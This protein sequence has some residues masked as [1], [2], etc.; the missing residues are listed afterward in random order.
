MIVEMKTLD[1]KLSVQVSA[2]ITT[3]NFK[4]REVK[5]MRFFKG[6]LAAY[7]TVVIYFFINNCLGSYNTQSLQHFYLGVKSFIS[8][9]TA[10]IFFGS[11]LI[12]PGC[13]LG[14]LLYNKYVKSK[15]IITG[16]I[17]FGFL[18]VTYGTIILIIDGGGFT[19][20]TS[21]LSLVYTITI[22][23]SILFYLFR[24]PWNKR[25]GQVSKGRGVIKTM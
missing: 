1:I 14:E 6:C 19:S 23:G 8:D 10:I 24:R 20:D 22:I 17:L 15:K 2:N 9:L 7:L 16:V 12:I 5:G 11:Y 4:D 18:G 25:T 3:Y 21:S 13:L